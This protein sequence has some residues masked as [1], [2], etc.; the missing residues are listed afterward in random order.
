M[1]YGRDGICGQGFI[2]YSLQST[3]AAPCLLYSDNVVEGTPN[4]TLAR[5]GNTRDV[6]LYE[7][8]RSVFERSY[9]VRRWGGA[10]EAQCHLRGVHSCHLAGAL[11]SLIRPVDNSLLRMLLRLVY[12]QC[13]GFDCLRRDQFAVILRSSL[14]RL[15]VQRQREVEDYQKLLRKVPVVNKLSPP[16][17]RCIAAV[18]STNS[19]SVPILLHA[20]WT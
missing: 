17:L 6:Y 20:P 5:A 15:L 16:L 3:L 14:Q 18:Q 1:A 9:E 19:L 8:E 10:A 12:L 4:K 13:P 2:H 7:L 11:K